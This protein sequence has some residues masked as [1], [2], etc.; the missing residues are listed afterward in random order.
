MAVGTVSSTILTLLLHR[1]KS[2]RNRHML[3]CHEIV[4]GSNGWTSKRQFRQTYARWQSN[5]AYKCSNR[6]ASW[7][8]FSCRKQIGV[9]SEIHEWLFRKTLT[10]RA[11]IA[12]YGTLSQICAFD[13][14][15]Y[16]WPW[17][18]LKAKVTHSARFDCKY[19]VNGK[20]QV[21]YYY[22]HKI[23][24]RTCA[25][26]CDIYIWPWPILKI[27]TKVTFLPQTYLKH[28]I[29]CISPYVSAYAAFSPSWHATA[30]RKETNGRRIKSSL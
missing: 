25:V 14:H 10:D 17:S 24:S 1:S 6:Q 16:M 15:I 20:R 13:W 3:V 19:L 12:I 29:R 22:C 5:F 4:P 7:H 23:G 9:H 8:S 2:S 18:I 30:S 21:W 27:N 26:D 28:T 11:E